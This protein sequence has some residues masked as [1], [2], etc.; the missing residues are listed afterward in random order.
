MT[1]AFVPSRINDVVRGGWFLNIKDYGAKGDGK[2]T[3]DAAI[4]SGHAT[5]TSASNPWTAADV[6]KT[7]GVYAAGSASA[8]LLTTIQAVNNAGNITLAANAVTTQTA[9]IAVWGTDDT[10]AINTAIA[11]ATPGQAVYFPAGYYVLAGSPDANSHAQISLP[12]REMEVVPQCGVYLFG[13]VIPGMIS[14]GTPLS[15]FALPT[16]EA[17]LWS[18]L[19]SANAVI[20]VAVPSGSSISYSSITVQI[21]NLCVRLP[22]NSQMTGID[23]SQMSGLL[24]KSVTVDYSVRYAPNYTQPTH[25]SAYGIKMPGGSNPAYCRADDVEVFGAYTGILVNEHFCGG[26]LA[27]SGCL[28]AAEVPGTNHIVQF[29]HLLIQACGNGINVTAGSLCGIVIDIMDGERGPSWSAPNYDFNDPNN[30]AY[31]TAVYW[32]IASTDS[33]RKNGGIN[34]TITKISHV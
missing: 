5:L 8:I 6:G 3:A 18:L 31:G 12:V 21:E 19:T 9:T 13:P 30:A 22:T 11:A 2:Y 25:S 32:S 29:H 7:I 26:F 10:A 14:Y 23:G 20:G 34:F 28:W 1:A 24:L 27:F 4:T 15:A 17:C 33:P 16:S